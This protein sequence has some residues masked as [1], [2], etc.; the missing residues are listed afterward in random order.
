MRQNV[1]VFAFVALSS[2]AAAAPQEARS[3]APR[4]ALV[5]S[6][7]GAAG[8]AHVGVI[9]EL[10]RIGVRPD[11]IVG[12]SMGAVVGGLYASG[13]TPD[14]LERAVTEV[15]WT[16]IL[17]D[18]SERDLV[19]PQRRDNRLD[20]FTTQADLPVGLGPDGPKV[21]A[22]LV[23]G[24]KLT[25]ILRELSYH[26]DAIEDFD[27][28]PIPFR[29]VA[30]DLLA[31]EP[32]VLG[33][34]DLDLAMRASMSIPGL[35]PPVKLDGRTLVDG[36]VTNNLPIDVARELGADIVIASFIPPAP[37]TEE[38]VE[39]LSGALGQSMAIFIH[40]RSRFLISTLGDD[41]VLLIPGVG[42]VGMLSFEQAPDTIEAGIASVRENAEALARIASARPAIAPRPPIGDTASA[43]IRYDRIVVRYDGV[44]DP[45]AIRRRL[46]LPDA[47]EVMPKDVERGVRRVYGMELFENVTYRLERED[48]GS[49][50]L[51]VVAEQANQGLLRPRVG[52]ALNNLFGGDSD[53]NF[54]AGVTIPEVNSLGGRF[55]IDVAIGQADGVR[56]QFEQPLDL[57]QQ[58]YIG[59]EGSYLNDTGTV[60]SAVD[61]P[62]AEINVEEF[63]GTVGFYWSP[64]AWGGFGPIV[65]YS[66]QSAEVELGS[67]P[68]TNSDEIDGDALLVGFVLDVDT[69]DDVDL[70][71]AGFQL[72]LRGGYDVLQSESLGEV[73]VDGIY[74]YSFGD[75]TFAPYVYVEGDIDPETFSAH[76]IGGFPRL[77][78][79]EENELVGNV[80]GV[81]GLRYYRRT[82]IIPFFG[83]DAFVGGSLSYG[84]AY[85][86]WGDVVDKDGGFVSTSLFAGIETSFGPAILS[87]G[88]AE[89]GQFAASFTLGARF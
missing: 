70:P 7:G 30:T 72:R 81:G 5:L 55:D 85:E 88:A 79:F 43:K 54:G 10:E 29:A 21:S 64:G 16:R 15:D 71:T 8:V 63:G 62:L 31:A 45:E 89:Q 73:A 48:D 40:A 66:H 67:L 60:F 3:A 77:P 46:D 87:F 58:F 47:G 57:D 13:F 20:P 76:F 52:L 86:S 41:D 17:D 42:D 53:F 25:L 69:I 51:V 74:A 44:L 36:G 34:G 22:G 32:V 27:A 12:T 23:D 4:I 39:S 24:V 49:S 26:V 83:R 80:V 61:D 82:S 2:F 35:F 18:A 1:L 37:A 56:V 14:D 84:G 50:S 65:S 9:K 11:L 68:G 38:D 6:G 59:V 19:Q 75:N 33:A 78:G 28:L